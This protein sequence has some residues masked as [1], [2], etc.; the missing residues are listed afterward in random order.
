MADRT[1]RRKKPQGSYRRKTFFKRWPSNHRLDP[2]AGLG[3]KRSHCQ[4]V[5]W[6]LQVRQAFRVGDRVAVVSSDLAAGAIALR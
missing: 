5:L 4:G 3:Q 1:E 6:R 2:A